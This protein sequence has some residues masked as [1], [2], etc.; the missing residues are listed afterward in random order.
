[1]SVFGPPAEAFVK[2]KAV[3]QVNALCFS[4]HHAETTQQKKKIIKTMRSVDRRTFLTKAAPPGA[5]L[6]IPARRET[7]GTHFSFPARENPGFGP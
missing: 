7:P 4:E 6:R 5:D 2:L 1:M 3:S